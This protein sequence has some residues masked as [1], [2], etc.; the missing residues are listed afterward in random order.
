MIQIYPFKALFPSK[1]NEKSVS[2]NTHIDDI[3]KQKEMV[4][5]NPH[6]YL[7]VVK[8]YLI[9]NEEKDPSK[10]FPFSKIELDKLILSK[11][12]EKDTQDAF[13]IYRQYNK[14]NGDEFL[15]IIS[16]VSV[17]DYYQNKI[18]IHENTITE[19]EEQLIEHIN[20]S[21]VIGEP[22]LMTHLQN[23]FVNDI[24]H[25]YEDSSHLFFEFEDEIK[26]K[27]SVYRIV[28]EDEVNLIKEKYTKLDNLYIAD[29]HHRSAASAGF[30]KKNHL[31]NGKY[32]A[33]IVPPEFLK[34][35]SFH[36]AY[37]C[38]KEFDVKGFIDSLKSCFFVDEVLTPFK[39]HKDKEFGLFINNQWYRL[40]YKG[41]VAEL[42]AVQTLDVSILENDVFQSILDINDSKTDKQLSFINGQIG[43]DELEHRVNEGLYDLVFTV[44]PCTIQQVFDVADEQL[45]MP[46]KSTYIE[47]KL[48]TGLVVQQVKEF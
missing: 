23:D 6:T 27:H 35:D 40:G 12:I 28:N 46:P 18:K 24:L 1:G 36:R 47:P 33:Y 14:V 38:N 42:N 43:L 17:D 4:A 30:F 19:K 48:R 37:K 32:L 44:F 25:H 8:P 34:I 3:D 11:I 5:N 9:F 20:C 22:V 39:P 13:Y 26:R 41:D 31:Q 29:G 16:L 15:G 21:G 45:I 2:A 7:R 10:H